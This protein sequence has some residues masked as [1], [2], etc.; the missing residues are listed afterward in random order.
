MS[1]RR[2]QFTSE[3]FKLFR[4]C[5]LFMRKDHRG[6][7]RCFKMRLLNFIKK[8]NGL[9]SSL[10]ATTQW[11]LLHRSRLI[12]LIIQCSACWITNKNWFNFRLLFILFSTRTH[13]R[14]ILIFNETLIWQ[15]VF[16]LPLKSVRVEISVALEALQITRSHLVYRSPS[17]TLWHS[18]SEGKINQ[19]AYCSMQWIR[20]PTLTGKTPKISW[21]GK[22]RST[23][24]IE[25]EP[26]HQTQ[27]VEYTPFRV[28]NLPI[29]GQFYHWH[30]R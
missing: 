30:S 19:K 11:G 1:V 20:F 4:S 9:N 14:G 23:K 28:F 5:F 7:L 18:Q 26:D 27:E 21:I 15:W 10:F 6:F 24:I 17:L 16:Q 8:L 22:H 25:R 2:S 13:Q 3:R 12:S 29:I